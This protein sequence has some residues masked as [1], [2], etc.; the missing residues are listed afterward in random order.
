ML[1]F[2]IGLLLISLCSTKVQNG[3]ESSEKSEKIVELR[4]KKTHV[5][6][7]SHTNRLSYMEAVSVG[8]HISNVGHC[9][10]L[11]GNLQLY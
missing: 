2:I 4:K 11:W 9:D 3:V 5:R 10:N 1:K 8:S 6:S 7:H